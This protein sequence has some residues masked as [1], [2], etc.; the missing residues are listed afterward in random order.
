MVGTLGV[1]SDSSISVFTGF[2]AAVQLVTV[3]SINREK[4]E[5]GDLRVSRR[6]IE[7]ERAARETVQGQ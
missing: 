5:G 4:I 6:S 2:A 1:I 3:T 7:V